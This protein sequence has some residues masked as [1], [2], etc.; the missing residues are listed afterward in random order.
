V[1]SA[2]SKRLQIDLTNKAASKY[3]D[4]AVLWQLHR[5]IGAAQAAADKATNSLIC[6][7]APQH[8]S[9]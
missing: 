4:I 7:F 1:S 2:A 6:W 8:S 3:G 9:G 5:S